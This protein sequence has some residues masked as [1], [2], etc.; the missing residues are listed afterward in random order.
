MTAGDRRPAVE[1]GTDEHSGEALGIIC[2]AV[3]AV[4]VHDVV[5]EREGDRSRPGQ[6]EEIQI[7]PLISGGDCDP[8]DPAARQRRGAIIEKL[9]TDRMFDGR[10]VPGGQ[11]V[12]AGGLR[13]DPDP[14]DPSGARKR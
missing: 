3:V 8:V 7:S 14:F 5:G 11:T 2:R 4:C 10:L 13:L 1:L 9:D 12:L 6:A